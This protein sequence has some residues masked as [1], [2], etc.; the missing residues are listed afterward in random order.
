M[1]PL[2]ME[3]PADAITFGIDTNYMFG[4]SILVCA[5]YPSL[6]YARIYLSPTVDWYDFYTSEIQNKS[7]EVRTISRE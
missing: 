6:D 5:T 1:R 3:F 2:W 7:S 4:N